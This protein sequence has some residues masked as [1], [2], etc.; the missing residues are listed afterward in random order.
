MSSREPKPPEDRPMVPAIAVVHHQRRRT[1]TVEICG[2]Q[3]FC[4]GRDGAERRARAF[5]RAM[6][7][8][9]PVGTLTI[10]HETRS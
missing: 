4:G 5:Q 2:I 10:S 9:L 6:M 7:K 1:C 8:H 3:A